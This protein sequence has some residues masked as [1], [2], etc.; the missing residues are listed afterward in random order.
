M[1]Q[2]KAAFLVNVWFDDS[3]RVHVRGSVVHLSTQERRYFTD[4][5]DLVAFLLLCSETGRAEIAEGGS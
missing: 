4:M 3:A 2:R 1:A 5:V